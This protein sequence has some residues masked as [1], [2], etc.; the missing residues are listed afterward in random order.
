MQASDARPHVL[1]I[2]GGLAGTAVA[3]RILKD[4]QRPIRLSVVES[5]A[6][7]G[8]GIAYGTAHPEHL[9]NGLA[10][11][12]SVYDDE[13]DH[14]VRWLRAGTQL[15]GWQPP[16]GVPLED[17]M[18]PRQVYGAYLRATLAAAL[19]RSAGLVEFRHLRARALDVV[20]QPAADAAHGGD[21]AHTQRW[22][23]FLDDDSQHVADELVL[24]TG[25]FAR[26]LARQAF[27]AGAGVA[28]S[29]RYVDDIWQAQAWDNVPQ[30]EHI[31]Y[32]GSGLSALDGL[33]MA[34]KA[35]F[36]GRHTV[37]SRRGQGVRAREDVAPWP[38]FLRYQPDAV[39]L[40]DLLA[41]IR[42]QRH[43]MR[44]QGENW[45]RLVPAIRMHVPQLWSLAGERDRRRFLGRLRSYWE[46]SLH[47]S[48]AAPLAWQAKVDAEGRYAH[49]AGRVRA[50]AL[51]PDGRLAVTWQPRT[52][53]GQPQPAPQTLVADRVVNCMG[54]E[55]DWRQ[56][57]DPLVRQ[58]VARGLAQPDP[59]GFGVQATRETH[60]LRDAAG[61]PQRGLYAVGHAL[62]GL[63]WESN[64]I[65][66]HVPQA[67]LVG[68]TV[69]QRLSL[70]ATAAALARSFARAAAASDE[71][72]ALRRENLQAAHRAGLTALAVPRHLGGLDL[73]L[74]Q[75]VPIIGE[76]GRGDPSTGL[77]LLMQTFH[78]RA[79]VQNPHWPKA[80]RETVLRAAAERGALVN[81]LRVEPEQGSPVRGGLPATLARRVEGGWRISGRKL[82]STG[83]QA[84]DWGLVWAGTD[85]ATPRV[86]EF[87]VPLDSPGVR[88]DPT[89]N[90]IGLRASGSHDVVFEDVFVPLD[91]GADLRP[92]AQWSSSGS[93]LGAWLPLMLA[94]LY[95]G[96]ARGARDWLVQWLQ[97]RQPSNLGK[98]LSALPRFQSGVGEIDAWLQANAAL[99]QRQAAA[100]A[101]D[102]AGAALVKYTVSRGAIAVVDKALALAG[103][104]GL[105]RHN[106]LERHFRD[107]LC[108]RVHHPQD[109]LILEGAGRHA[110]SSTLQSVTA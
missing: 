94:A 15:G 90:H 4:V 1:I 5:R 7:L 107:V 97:A 61:Q 36:R 87:L 42:V 17:S 26:P 91:H 21:G 62:R 105:T 84:L 40:R 70:T 64:A 58:L 75:V 31:V 52:V 3:L 88:I 102:G 11:L 38:D 35:G 55:F 18:P 106:P 95:D 19:A 104:H 93:D 66:E 49:E 46:A 44:R 51:R 67:G 6:E 48:A 96:V 34:E 60:A 80:L 103:N 53:P 63:I 2:G 110:F 109:D 69:V 24:A 83:A 108:S 45:Q 14:L 30:H 28:D 76:I 20:A 82:Y 78:H 33:I 86:G 29:P 32:L 54:F 22:R 13:P 101:A 9:V 23:V 74:A 12:F 27:E 71:E 100:S 77:I 25:I 92:L 37:L 59:L 98:P 47:R 57:E 10:K 89:W 8:L 39:S 43:A 50:I 81:A 85:E 79:I 99:L 56:I 72:G 65:P 41:Q 73:P 16:P 68:R